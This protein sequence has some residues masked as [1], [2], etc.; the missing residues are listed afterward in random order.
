MRIIVFTW[1]DLSHPAAGGAEVFTSEI[2]RYWVQWGHEV[3]IFASRHVGSKSQEDIDGVR[4]LR[5]GTRLTV[6]REARKF[7]KRY[8]EG[9]FDLVIDQV[10]TRP[11]LTPR[12]VRST[13]IL[14]LIY[15]LAAE[16]WHEEVPPLASHIGRYLLEPHWL[17]GYRQCQT[18]TISASTK[19][20]LCRLGFERVAV[21]KPGLASTSYLAEEI[22]KEEQP[23]AIFVG[24]MVK[25]K[26]PEHALQAHKLMR[27]VLPHV[28]LWLVGD[29]Y[30]RRKL[31]NERVEGV[32]FFGHVSQ[33][34][35]VNL[36][37]RAHLA[38]IPGV[39]E[40]WGLVVIEANAVETPAVGYDIPGLR[41][42]ILD[43]KTGFLV[44]P[45]PDALAAGAVQLLQT[46]PRLAT[47]RRDAKEW[48]SS[49]DWEWTATTLLDL[50]A[51]T[52]NERSVSS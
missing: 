5:V 40:G 44:E 21:V 48:A 37:S 45:K 29:G 16:V 49:F 6:Y 30:L 41:D 8:G 12:Y 33:E 11:F 31:E 36:L 15:Q 9:A 26:R 50:A 32:T 35:K 27:Q 39:R 34:K 28:Q 22:R 20:D 2:A 25:T 17:R 46:P 3:T 1:K 23:T 47:M 18:V 10:N 13:P 43:G 14:C 7:W 24:R 51:A 52:V 19:D 4:I 38:L 42:S